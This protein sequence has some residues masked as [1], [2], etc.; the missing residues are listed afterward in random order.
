MRAELLI[1]DKVKDRHEGIIEVKVWLVPKSAGKPHGYKIQWCMLNM[2][3][4]F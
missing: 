2:V 3:S 1:H 4:V